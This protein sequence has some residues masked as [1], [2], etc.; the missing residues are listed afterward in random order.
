MLS[1]TTSKVGDINDL[2]IAFEDDM[3]TSHGRAYYRLLG[4]CG[5]R[6][7]YIYMYMYIIVYCARHIFCPFHINFIDAWPPV[8]L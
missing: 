5:T 3:G 8:S 4:F 2:V 7:I 6:P 1:K